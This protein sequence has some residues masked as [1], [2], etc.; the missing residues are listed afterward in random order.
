MPSSISGEV[1]S[2]RLPISWVST[3]GM[4]LHMCTDTPMLG[5]SSNLFW[6]AVAGV[7]EALHC[8][9][10]EIRACC[11]PLSEGLI[12]FNNPQG[13]TAASGALKRRMGMH[14]P[15]YLLDPEVCPA[16]RIYTAT[17]RWHA[18]PEF[19]CPLKQSPALTSWQVSGCQSNC[20]CMRLLAP[21][22]SLQCQ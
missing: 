8:V 9:L 5:H 2:G 21:G 18:I 4:H 22:N 20:P 10:P 16:C 11:R 6:A 19:F 13:L 7:S 14:K 15:F 3:H 17:L 12:Q 1:S